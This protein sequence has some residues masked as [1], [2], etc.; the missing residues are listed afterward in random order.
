MR[1][2]IFFKNVVLLLII[3]AMVGCNDNDPP[4]DSENTPPTTPSI[5]DAIQF[6]AGSVEI[7]WLENQDDTGVTGYRVFR[8]GNFIAEVATT[9]YTD[10]GLTESGSHCYTV[11]AVDSVGNESSQ[12]T[13]VCIDKIPGSILW[14]YETQGV[15]SGAPAISEDGTIYVASQDGCLYA[16]SPDGTLQWIFNTN[17]SVINHSSP[18]VSPDGTI[19]LGST[20]YLHAI[21][22]DGSLKWHYMA[23]F[24]STPA[25]GKDGTVYVGDRT[26]SFYAIS[27]E[28]LLKW[29][30]DSNG[31]SLYPP[32][33][34]PDGVIYA[35]WSTIYAVQKDSTVKWTLPFNAY[36]DATPAIGSS[37]Q[38]YVGANFALYAC[39]SD[40]E[41]NWSINITSNTSIASVKPA[42]RKKTRAPQQSV[43]RNK[44]N[45]KQA[46]TEIEIEEVRKLFREY[47]TFLDVDLCF[48]DF[49]NE[50]SGLPGKYTFPNGKLLIAHD[51]D[52]AVGCVALRKLEN[53]VCEMKRLYVKPE[54]RGDRGR[55]KTCSRDNCYC[56]RTWIF[57]N[58]T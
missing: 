55:Q 37:G 16:L 51:G 20:E 11:S 48:Q 52:I 28:G 3:L 23:S 42:T 43:G 18:A 17:A 21:N 9:A 19:Y 30:K 13:A 22:P 14:K 6:S 33:I 41:I 35:S 36:H 50:L 45:I 1:F 4:N 27:P 8:D 2:I 58:A 15:I 47:E 12:S 24:Y 40:S 49:E 5:L 56:T 44:M 7:S 31:T 10:T 39:T 26:S 54:A 29:K 38:I 34:G 25:V 57:I 46:Q 32:A 53:N